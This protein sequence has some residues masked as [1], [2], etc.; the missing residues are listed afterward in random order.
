MNLL[1]LGM[2]SVTMAGA[3]M[4]MVMANS[5]AAWAAAKYGDA[6]VEQ[7]TMTI[8][9][10]G[11]SINFAAS[12]KPVPV[13]EKDLV[14]VRDNSRVQLK[15]AD[16]ASVT[17]GANAVFQV[18]PWQQQEQKGMFRMLFGRFRATVTGLAGGERFNVK[19]ATATIGVKGTEYSSA[20]TTGGYTSVLGIES[21]VENTGSDGVAQPIS[22]GQVSV[23]ASPA[24]PAIPAPQEFI[25][26]MRN[27][28]SPSPWNTAALYL[29][30]MQALINAGVVSPAALDKWKQEQAE[31]GGGEGGGANVPPPFKFDDA[32]QQG[33]LFKG[34]LRPNFQK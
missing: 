2:V 18:E 6:M 20:V 30:A 25:D 15:T 33:Q 28:N 5:P 9:R 29:P 31:A 3:V 17:L 12:G 13:N 26:A 14:R 10:E 8:V 32:Q 4:A 34:K 24:T 11:Q 16:S 1:K 19:T 22:P 21:V 7:G 23:T 27:L